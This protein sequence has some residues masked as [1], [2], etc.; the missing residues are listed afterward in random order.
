[1]LGV[2]LALVLGGY[3]AAVAVQ[4]GA[5][6][7]V[8]VTQGLRVFPLPGWEVAQSPFADIDSV[9]LTKGSGTLD[10][11]A[12]P[13]EGAVEGLYE[14]YATRFLEP[15]ARQLRVARPALV[16]LESGVVA[17]RGGYVGLFG[18]VAS[19]IEGEITVLISPGGLGVVFD[20]WSGQGQL[21]RTI[22]EARRMIDGAE[23]A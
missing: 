8:Q 21:N 10:V 9:R 17:L 1:M 20:A 12:S 6:P 5:G 3:A 15:G 2:V 19:A 18:D 23:V 14:L 11:L 16:E 22:E 7:P 13:F 4:P